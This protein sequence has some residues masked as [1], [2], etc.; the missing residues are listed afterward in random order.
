MVEATFVNPYSAESDTW[1]YGLLL[2]ASGG[3]TGH[4]IRIQSDGS[5]E[6]I[7]I[8]I[9]TQRVAVR[10]EESPYINL[11][12]GGKN[13]LRLILVGNDGWLIINGEFEDKLDL[14]AV[15]GGGR[16][17][18]Y[19][20]DEKD[21]KVTGLEDFTVWTWNPHLA[22]IPTGKAPTPT[23]IPTPTL[24]PVTVPSGASELLYRDDFDDSDSEWPISSGDT[25]DQGYSKG[26][27]RFLVK[28]AGSGNWAQA[29]PSFT[30]FDVRVQARNSRAQAGNYGLIFRFQNSDNYYVFWVNP[31]SGS[32]R[33]IKYVSGEFSTMIPWGNSPF[34]P[35]GN[36]PIVLRVVARG[37]NLTF[38]VN[39]YQIDNLTD[40]SFRSGRIGLWVE[41][42]V[43]T[44]GAE[45][46]FD[47]L[48][49]FSLR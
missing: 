23:P 35:R 12:E 36:D 9:G 41:N 45:V 47:N 7:P 46:F 18:A 19:V 32:Y 42:E 48:R 34:I 29:I 37:A 16:T 15:P 44:D 49:V 22:T 11:F 31:A 25:Y 28:K 5:W 17:V 10:H 30:D 3:N 6:R 24:V 26:E 2:R 39:D 40:S 27:Y 43:A 33:A 1:G 21:G 8:L 4:E 14:S 38:Y 20:S 13:H